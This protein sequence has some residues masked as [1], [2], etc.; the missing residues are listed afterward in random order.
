MAAA[1]FVNTVFGSAVQLLT[2]SG[3][4]REIRNIVIGTGFFSLTA[5]MLFSYYWGSTGAASAFTISLMLQ[6]F[7]AVR[8][9][10]QLLGINVMPLL[11]LKS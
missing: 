8:K 4:Q 7:L 9:V 2:M 5:T 11:K 10:R 6:N 1:Y 3:H